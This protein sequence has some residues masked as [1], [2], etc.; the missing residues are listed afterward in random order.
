M[1]PCSWHLILGEPRELWHMAYLFL[2][3]GEKSGLQSTGLYKTNPEILSW[4]EKKRGFSSAQTRGLFPW[5][6]Q[7]D[8]LGRL[9]IRNGSASHLHHWVCPYPGTAHLEHNCSCHEA[10]WMRSTTHLGWDQVTLK[11]FQPLRSEIDQI[12]PK[13]LQRPLVFTWRLFCV[14]AASKRHQDGWLVPRGNKHS[15]VLELRW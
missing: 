13:V 15:Q 6:P 5:L 12:C 14:H 1:A 4:L 9:G 11:G 10:D 7:C 2:A 8:E 3:R